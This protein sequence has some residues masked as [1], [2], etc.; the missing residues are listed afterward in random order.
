M[1]LMKQ[2]DNQYDRYE[3]LKAEKWKHYN[4]TYINLNIDY[5]K[6]VS[7][8]TN[9]LVDDKSIRLAV[10]IVTCNLLALKDEFVLAYSRK[11]VTLPVTYNKRKISYNKIIKATEWLVANGYALEQRGKATADPESRYASTLWP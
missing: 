10:G 9:A 4:S 11:R 7:N 2:E 8:V 6:Q 1:E 5:P 3:A